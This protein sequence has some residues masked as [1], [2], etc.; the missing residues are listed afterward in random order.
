MK[1]LRDWSSTE[2]LVLLALLVAFAVGTCA[3]SWQV[4]V[5]ECQDRVP[6]NMNPG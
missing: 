3:G 1:A 5:L 4:D 6:D 2:C